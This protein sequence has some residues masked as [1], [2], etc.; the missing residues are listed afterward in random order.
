MK[1]EIEIVIPP[2]RLNDAEF[3]R[4]LSSQI[5][6]VN[7]S[8]ISAVR[9]IRR[10][11]DARSKIPVYRI[12]TLV[13]INEQP[14]EIRKQ[15]EY[16]S[17]E[18]KREVIIVGMGP[19]GMFAALRLIELGIKPILVERG[20]DVQTRRKDLK[21]IQ[22]G[23][24]VN[25]DSN[26][27]FGEGGAGTYSDGKLYTRSTKRGD[28]GRILNI[29]V[30]HGAHE[31][32]LIDAHPHIGSNKLPIV[33]QTIREIILNCG[34]E[35]HF[36][37]R[38]T[39]FIQTGNKITGVV[40]NNEKELLGES[41]ILA[42]G[43]SARDIYYLLDKHKIKLEAK[44]FAIGVRIEHP[45]TLIDEIQYH[46]KV[47]NPY[48]PASSYSLTCQVDNRGVYSFCMCPGGIIIPASTDKD[49]LVLN[50]MSVSRRDSSF[51]N[52]GFVVSVN[53]ND[54]KEYSSFG[55][56][57][58]L[59]F[60]KKIEKIAFEAGGKT[61]RAPAQRITDFVKEKISS[62]LPQ[63]SYIPGIVSSPLH[64]LLPKQITNGLKQSL[65]LFDK[66]MKG[67]LTEEAQI[68]AAETRTSSPIKIP[69]DSE[70]LMHTEVEGLFPCGEGAGYAG[71]IVS[72]A[73]D[74]ERSADAVC[75]FL[76]F[77]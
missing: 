8:E 24:Y 16:K 59:E 3:L 40:I 57:A 43:H 69:R 61:Q 52:S 6:R 68:L 30:Q 44:P 49:E 11:L 77:S 47:R 56:F 26:Y 35:I 27:C 45:Q 2:D 62:S 75:K 46:S 41:V 19:A 10:S 71:G 74:G 66:K 65:F 48:L 55:V 34:G 76:N 60:Q 25:P 28:V 73:I 18:S 21:A 12:K 36:D 53:E 58:G 15:I 42:T 22:Q 33:V 37:S 50:G 31:E 32:I 29:L 63:T 20:K 1:H 23:G 39:D 67:Y 9:Q 4:A 51:A 7:I 54:W 72:A 64:E 17:V 13:Y 38:V 70:T 5:L 14:Q